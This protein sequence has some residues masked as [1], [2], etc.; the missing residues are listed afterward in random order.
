MSEPVEESLMSALVNSKPRLCDADELLGELQDALAALAD[1]E[2]QYDLS[3]EKSSTCDGSG[4]N[5]RSLAGL[6][7]CHE[8][9]RALHIARVQELQRRI[10]GHRR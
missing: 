4:T 7:A 8:R 3:R 9:D 1:I 10:M 5:R 2:I 6:E